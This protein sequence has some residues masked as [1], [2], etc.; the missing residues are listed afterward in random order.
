MSANL[1]PLPIV[2][3]DDTLLVI[4]KPAGLPSLP[5]GYDPAAPHV[6]SLLEPQFG[7]LWIVHRLD[8][9]TSGVLLLARSVEAHRFLNRQFDQRL[10]SKL[11]HA[12]VNGLPEWDTRIVDLPLRADVGH[13]HRTVVDQAHGKQ[14]ETQLRVLERFQTCALVEAAPQT[15]RTH[16]IR[17]HLAAVGHPLVGDELYGSQAGNL[18][19][20]MLRLGL[21][22]RQLTI[23]HPVQHSIQ[24]FEAP[25]PYDFAYALTQL[26]QAG[27]P[28]TPSELH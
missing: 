19:P 17:A 23:E 4:D 6:R 13:K 26:R 8:R 9:G 14:A 25:Y 22:A 2:Y 27:N 28:D 1:S 10:V 15:G 11:Y 18:P 24:H 5:D 20:V 16:Q 12:L 3:I 7:R 21:H